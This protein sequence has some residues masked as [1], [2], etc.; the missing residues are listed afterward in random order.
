[1]DE[2]KEIITDLVKTNNYSMSL[3]KLM[4][5]YFDRTQEHLYLEVIHL[6]LDSIPHLLTFFDGFDLKMENF[7]TFDL[8]IRPK[9][10]PEQE[11]FGLGIK[12][13]SIPSCMV[14]AWNFLFTFCRNDRRVRRP[15][16][17]TL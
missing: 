15:Q 13:V 11:L 17:P 16:L 1:M 6:G 4:T 9:D 12:I 14:E 7:G 8:H 2:L 5:E 3:T 10:E